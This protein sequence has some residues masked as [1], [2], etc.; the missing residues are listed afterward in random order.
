MRSSL[1]GHRSEIDGRES[2]I[3]VERDDMVGVSSSR[4]GRWKKQFELT[5]D[6]VLGDRIR[7]DGAYA[8]AMWS[9]LANV[10]WHGPED[11]SVSYSFRTAGDLVAWVREEGDYLDWYCAGARC[12]GRSVDRGGPWA[13]GMV[14][15]HRR[16]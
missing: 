8:I 14:S 7:A 6:R 2:A 13:R 10:E 12:R 11:V 16:W 3:F 15:A 1:M 5:V 9:A 4:A